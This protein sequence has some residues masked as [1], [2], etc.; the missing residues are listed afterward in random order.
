MVLQQADHRRHPIAAVDQWRDERRKVV[1]GTTVGGTRV[2]RAEILLQHTPLQ[3]LELARRI[4]TERVGEHRAH[5][6]VAAKRVCLQPGAVLG[7]D[8]AGPQRLAQRVLSRRTGE[9][10]H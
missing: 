3:V 6:L 10:R 5:L 7:S 8:Q 1:A 4:E 9:I 2:C